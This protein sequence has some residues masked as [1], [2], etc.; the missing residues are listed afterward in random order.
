MANGVIWNSILLHL[1]TCTPSNQMASENGNGSECQN[2][3]GF[4]FGLDSLGIPSSRGFHFS[5][6]S[7]MESVVIENASGMMKAALL[8]MRR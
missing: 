2:C 5:M 7:E 4:G 6:A 8:T 1:M 3:F